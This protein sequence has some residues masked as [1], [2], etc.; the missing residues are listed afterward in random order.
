[1]RIPS[2]RQ[3][4][5]IC[6][7][8]ILT[9]ILIVFS[10]ANCACADEALDQLLA[11]AM[12]NNPD[13]ITSKAKVALAEAELNATRLQVARRILTLRGDLE[14]QKIIVDYA[15]KTQ[16]SGAPGSTVKELQENEAKLQ[17]MENEL[18]FLIG[19][20]GITIAP[21]MSVQTLSKP[22]QIP[23]GAI[24][25]K[26][27]KEISGKTIDMDF[28]EVPLQQVID[29]MTDYL[30]YPIYFD[31]NGIGERTGIDPESI[32]ITLHMKNTPILGVFQAIEDQHPVL[33]IVLRDYGVLITSIDQAKAQGYFP[34]L[35]VNKLGEKEKINPGPETYS[36]TIYNPELKPV[37]R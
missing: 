10:E 14:K 11:T 15:Q 9:G 32:V 24:V 5:C 35:E 33:K 20:D 16:Q 18:R 8:A 21:A 3:S 2:F 36:P 22:L 30:E 27:K 13:I 28:V 12:E 37:P 4:A 29:Y 19:K 34:A 6:T 7:I 23:T 25:D 17:Q 31:K 1:M 26:F